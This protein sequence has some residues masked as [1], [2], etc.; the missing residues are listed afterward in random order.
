M[1]IYTAVYQSIHVYTRVY[2]CTLL[3]FTHTR[4]WENVSHKHRRYWA[5]VHSG[6]GAA[7]RRVQIIVR[8]R[9]HSSR[10]TDRAVRYIPTYFFSTR[11]RKDSLFTMPVQ[12]SWPVVVATLHPN[13][14]GW[15]GSV[16]T[17]NNLNPW[18]QVWTIIVTGSPPSFFSIPIYSN[19]F[20]VICCATLCSLV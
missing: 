5:R 18:Y 9:A 1:R 7:R 2:L 8:H 11:K 17:R 3:E 19:A 6:V 13:I 15:A 16:I 10:L 14:G 4:N 12:I 20:D